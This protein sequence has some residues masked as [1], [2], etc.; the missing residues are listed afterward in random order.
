LI[1]ARFA[2]CSHAMK[3]GRGALALLVNL[4][5]GPGT[6]VAAAGRTRR[7][8]VWAGASVLA[9]LLMVISLWA[10]IAVLAILVGSSLDAAVAGMRSP[11]PLRVFDTPVAT[12]VVLEIVVAVAAHQWV[13]EAF[14]V[15]SSSMYP[16]VVIG[17]HLMI[18]KLTP[19][20][21]AIER[22]EVIVFDYPC[23][24]GR[25]YLK[26]VV[27]VGGDTVEIRCNVEW[28][29][30]V[31]VP[32]TRV[33]GECS[34]DD[35]DE[36]NDQWTP[37]TCSRYTEMLGGHDYD[38]FHDPERPARDAESPRAGDNRDF[39]P[40][41]HTDPPACQERERSAAP[42]V[43]GTVVATKDGA[44]ACETQLHYVVPP[45]HLFVLGDNRNNSNDS[46]VWGSVP[47]ASVKGRVLGVWLSTNPAY[48]WWSRIGAVH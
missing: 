28:V 12:I 29:N 37:R 26:R 17:D 19:R 24:A 18:D 5:L 42:Q 6:G 43:L 15:P 1:R 21:R 40:L 47:V 11:R 35:Y 16:T 32:S 20:V 46:R 34:Y 45:D 7:A 44:P 33:A 9:V 41:G 3:Y 13:V 4:V 10:T 36:G 14:K 25:R 30:G 2:A 38:T 8:F 39:P 22:G 27:A 23:D 31:A 48:R